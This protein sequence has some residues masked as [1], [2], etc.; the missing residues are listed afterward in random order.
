M[1]TNMSGVLSSLKQGT[2]KTKKKVKET[3]NTMSNNGLDTR[4]FTF[5]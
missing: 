2:N 1:L 5:W 3:K 4:K